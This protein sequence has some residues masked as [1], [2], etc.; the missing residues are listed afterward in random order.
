[1]A[2]SHVLKKQALYRVIVHGKEDFDALNFSLLWQFLKEH[3][4]QIV[5]NCVSYNLIDNA[6]TSK[7]KAW[8]MNVILPEKLAEF[9]NSIGGYLIHFSTFLIFDGKKNAPYQEED[10]PSPLG[11]YGH[12]KLQ[13]ERAIEEGDLDNFLII[14]TSWLFGPWR[15]NFVQYI[16]EAS[17]QKKA[18][19]AI[20]DQIGTPTYTLDLANYTSL[21]I[22]RHAHGIF[23]V[24]NSGEATWC[25]LATETL[26]ILGRECRVEPITSHL[27]HQKAKRPSYGVLDTSKFTAYTGVKPR[28]WIVA[29]RDFLFSSYTSD[30]LSNRGQV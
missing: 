13:G 17:S 21:L 10:Q 25:E 27:Y 24:C 5:V 18:V 7:K 4:P 26:S 11:F 22:K 8:E 16:I 14:R 20:H 6:E 3:R 1:M 30:V 15:P 23:H 2:L 29:L 19:T 12:S 9:L 28:P